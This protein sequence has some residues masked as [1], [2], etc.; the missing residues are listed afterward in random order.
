MTTVD[1]FHIAMTSGN[2]LSPDVGVIGQDGSTAS[3]Q[4]KAFSF[5]DAAMDKCVVESIRVLKLM[6]CWYRGDGRFL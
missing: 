6:I 3:L 5:R 4:F 1:P 2:S